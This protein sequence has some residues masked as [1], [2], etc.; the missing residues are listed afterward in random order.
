V[1]VDVVFCDAYRITIGKDMVEITHFAY[2]QGFE[3]GD[4][5]VMPKADGSA[6]VI[7][8]VATFRSEHDEYQDTVRELDMREFSVFIVANIASD[9]ADAIK[10]LLPDFSGY[11]S[12]YGKAFSLV[13]DEMGK[14]E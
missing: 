2:Y 3:N 4:L 8:Q 6:N 13:L 10:R 5:V 1:W 14:V 12:L 11:H 7:E 9:P